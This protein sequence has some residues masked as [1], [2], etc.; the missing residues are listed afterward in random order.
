MFNRI[1]IGISFAFIIIFIL[2]ILEGIGITG[3]LFVLNVG[4]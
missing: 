4:H 3:S 2:N 1:F